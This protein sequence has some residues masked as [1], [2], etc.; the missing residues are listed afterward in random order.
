MITRREAGSVRSSTKGRSLTRR[1]GSRKEERTSLK[2]QLPSLIYRMP[3]EN[4]TSLSIAMGGI[5]C[6]IEKKKDRKRKKKRKN[7]KKD[8]KKNR[9]R[10][11]KKEDDV[12]RRCVNEKIFL[13]L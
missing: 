6:S 7:K 8:R 11:G 10:S 1:V 4:V 9:K 5:A 2:L 13:I 3:A 12:G